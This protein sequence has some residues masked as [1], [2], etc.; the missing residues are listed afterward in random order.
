MNAKRVGIIGGGIVGTAL[1][2]HLT[3]YENVEVTLFDKDQIGSGTTAKSAG[4]VCLFD[5]SVSHEFWPV[6][7]LGFRS[8]CAMEQEEKGSAGFAN[9]GTLVVAT[10]E[11]VQQFVKQG[12][13]L[14][15]ATGYC[16]E[17]IEDPDR[18]RAI[19]PDL[20][21][22][23]ILGAGW[24]ADDG[25]FDAPLAANTFARKARQKGAKIH[26]YTK[27]EKVTL[28]GGRVTG[29]D[30]S[31]GHFELDVVVNATGPWARFTGRMVDLEL[32]LWHTKAEA[33]FLVP[34]SK[35]L[36]YR[37]PVLKYPT[38]YAR[39]DHDNIFICKAHLTMD[40][41]DPMH[42]GI[43]DP[44]ALAPRGGTDQYFLDFIFGELEKFAP[45]LL[46]TQASF[47][48]L[49]Y[50]AEPPDFLPILGESGVDGYLLAVGF[51][52]NGVIE[53]PMAGRD[54]A[55]YIA[56]GDKSWLL[57][58]LAFDRFKSRN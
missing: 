30:T 43:W 35:K 44:D 24:T 3:E 46:D 1:A 41:N 7:L 53:G 15:T 29:V 56:T 22:E 5:D 40:L 52:G 2:Y 18:I 25:Y 28:A 51:G 58:R 31:A 50:R 10:D 55:R 54:L 26:T 21:T 13:A 34:P 49:G 39:P 23:G 38:F 11:K 14:A 8:Y 19:V 45:G 20:A 12:I 32:P 37:F 9:V 16:A 4:T 42:A 48:W 6:R 17:W 57:D 33:F 36:S 47:S 27:V